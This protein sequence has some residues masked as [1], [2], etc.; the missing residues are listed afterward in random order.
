M[1]PNGSRAVVGDQTG[2]GAI[3]ILERIRTLY[4]GLT[5]SQQ[6]VADYIVASYHEA[7]FM[8]ASDMARQVAMNE[9]TVVRFAQR[10]GYAGYPDLIRDIQDTVRQDLA[11]ERPTGGEADADALAH[12]V[13]TQIASLGRIVSHLPLGQSRSILLALDRA[14]HIYA[15]GQG[16]SAPLAQLLAYG[17]R[18]LGLPAESP[19]TDEA[20]L[21]I[22]LRD[23]G[24]GTAVVGLSIDVE[25]GQ[26]ANALQYARDRGASTIALCC[27]PVSPCALAAEM[28]LSCEVGDR[29]RLP[30]IS[31]MALLIEGL[32][33]CLAARATP[34]QASALTRELDQ[35]REL[36]SDSKRR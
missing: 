20:T 10:L 11:G 2:V 31:A 22:W 14:G 8:T 5:A 24:P 32:L 26:V 15:L 19:Q 33:H 7:A 35:A 18:R 13:R 16:L 21:A 30:E 29:E 12:Q 6:R 27:S 34:E 3:V 1:Q 4:S 9:S 17:L 23:A 36:I 28:V 25:G